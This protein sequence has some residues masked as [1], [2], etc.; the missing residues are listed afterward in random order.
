MVALNPAVQGK[1]DARRRV[2]RDG[3]YHRAVPG[4]KLVVPV[5][6]GVIAGFGSWVR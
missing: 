2:R 4:E 1:Q 6:G 5:G 3:P